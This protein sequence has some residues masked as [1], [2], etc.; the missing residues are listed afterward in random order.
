MQRTLLAIFLS[1]VLGFC[2]SATCIAAQSNIT[3]QLAIASI[4]NSDNLA[5]LITNNNN[6]IAIGTLPSFAVDGWFEVSLANKCFIDYLQINGLTGRFGN[7]SVYYSDANSVWQPFFGYRNIGFAAG[8]FDLSYGN[9]FTGNLRFV[10][11][12]S[13]LNTAGST[14]GG[15]KIY[16]HEAEGPMLLKGTISVPNEALS[17]PKSFL[18]DGNTNTTWRANNVGNA[19]ISYSLFDFSATVSSIK[20]YTQGGSG[21]ATFEAW[22]DNVNRWISLRS[23]VDLGSVADGWHLFET[24]DIST[25][26]IRISISTGSGYSYVGGIAEMQVWG[27]STGEYGQSILLGEKFTGKV[28]FGAR[29]TDISEWDKAEIVATVPAT[30]SS[31]NF[32]LSVNGY[33]ITAV[34]TGSLLNSYR[35]V[36]IPVPIAKLQSNNN[37]VTLDFG[38][39]QVFD[40]SLML[41][42]TAGKIEP[43]YAGIGVNQP[44]LFDRNRFLSAVTGTSSS[45]LAV[46]WEDPVSLD[47]IRLYGSNE[48]GSMTIQSLAYWQNGSW[49]QVPAAD[50]VIDGMNISITG[51]L[52]ATTKIQIHLTA[53]TLNEIELYGSCVS[54]KGAPV[55]TLLTPHSNA[56]YT[57]GETIQVTGYVD[58]P[59]TTVLVNGLAAQLSGYYFSCSLTASTTGSGYHTITVSATDRQGQST[60]KSVI[61]ITG[62]LPSLTCDLASPHYTADA[63]V[64]VTGTS[65]GA[66]RVTINAQAVEVNAGRYSGQVTLTDGE[67]IVAI[68]AINASNLIKRLEQRIILDTKAP[69]LNVNIAKSAEDQNQVEVFGTVN[70]LSP[71]TVTINGKTVNA[72]NGYIDARVT[73]TQRS[74]TVVA[75]DV[76]G[77]RTIV[78]L[79]L[80]NNSEFSSMSIGP[81]GTVTDYNSPGWTNIGDFGAAAGP[82]NGLFSSTREAVSQG[83][84]SI[85]S[86]D[87]TLPGR[88][89]LNLTLKRFYNSGAAFSDSLANQE[90]VFPL[91]PFFG[92]QGWSL[93][94]PCIG[95]KSED[96]DLTTT[97]SDYN[98]YSYGTEYQRKFYLRLPEGQVVE[99]KD[100]FVHIY[101]YD[102]SPTPLY[103]QDGTYKYNKGTHFKAVRVNEAITVTSN[104]GTRFYFD[105]EGMLTRQVDPSGKSE[106]V[107][108]YNGENQ[109]SQIKDSVGRV[110]IFN[111]HPVTKFL[112]SISCNNQP[113]ASYAYDGTTKDLIAVT[114]RKGRKTQYAYEVHSFKS[115][116]NN[117][118]TCNLRLL[119]Q[120]TYPTGGISSYE[121]IGYDQWTKFRA[122]RANWKYYGFKYL[123]QNHRIDGNIIETY[124]YLLNIDKDKTNHE[125]C[126]PRNWMVLASEV[127]TTVAHGRGRIHEEYALISNNAIINPPS[128]TWFVTYSNVIL[129]RMGDYQGTLLYSHTSYIAV[130]ENPNRVYENIV[131]TYDNVTQNMLSEW[132]TSGNNTYSIEYAYDDWGNLTYT[133]DGRTGIAKTVTYKA[134]EAQDTYEVPNR[135]ETIIEKETATGKVL[136]KT[137]YTYKDHNLPNKPDTVTVESDGQTNASCFEY[138]TV[139][140]LTK[141]SVPITGGK[142]LI[143][144]YSYKDTYEN[145]TYIASQTTETTRV[146]DARGNVGNIVTAF[147]Y[148]YFG[149]KDWEMDPLGY[150]T[151]YRYD[152]LQRPTITILPDDNTQPSLNTLPGYLNPAVDLSTLQHPIRMMSYDD[153]NNTTTMLNENGQ[154][155][156]TQYTKFGKPANVKK[157]N[158]GKVVEETSIQYDSQWR[159]T[160]VTDRK[161]TTGYEYDGLDRIVKVIYPATATDGSRAFVTIVYDDDHHTK[162]FTNEN[163]QVIAIETYNLAGQLLGAV[164]RA[165]YGGKDEEYKW[166]YTYD[167]L[168]NKLTVTKPALKNQDNDSLLP[169]AVTT[170][171]YQPLVNKPIA[172]EL[173]NVLGIVAN[174]DN[175]NKNAFLAPA[176]TATIKVSTV[177]DKMG[178]PLQT[179][180]ANGNVTNYVYDELTRLLKTTQSFKQYDY[181]VKTTE[182]SYTYDAAGRKTTVRISDPNAT[183]LD[184]IW[185]YDYSARGQLLK[186]TDPAGNVTQYRYDPAGNKIAVIDPRN[187]SDSANS[188]YQFSGTGVNR[189]VTIRDPRSNKTFTTW[190]LY[191]DLNRPVRTVMPGLA[192]DLDPFGEPTY[193]NPHTDVSYGWNDTHTTT[194]ETDAN[195]V[196]ITSWYNSRNWLT[197]IY[198]NGL[199]KQYFVY[200]NAGN[201]TAEYNIVKGTTTYIHTQYAYDS[202]GRVRKVVAPNGTDVQLFEYDAFGNRIKVSVGSTAT[203]QYK[204]TMYQYNQ[205]GKVV[206]I[207]DPLGNKTESRYDPNGNP[208]AVINAKRDVTIAR[209]DG[210]NRVIKAIDANDDALNPQH[211]VNYRYDSYGNKAGV[212]DRRGTVWVY[213]Y[214]QNNQIRQI[215]LYT[216]SQV[217]YQISYDYDPAGNLITVADNPGDGNGPISAIRYNTD[218]SG[219]YRAD[220]LNR[221]NAVERKFDG[222]TYRT[223]YQYNQGGQ[224]TGLAYPK[225]AGTVNY[226]YDN[227]NQLS[228][229]VGF[230]KS[231]GVSYDP[232]GLLNRLTYQNG[233]TTNFNYDANRRLADLTTSYSGKAIINSHYTYD[234]AS[235][236]TKIHDGIINQDYEYTFDANDQL[237]SALNPQLVSAQTPSNGKNGMAVFDFKGSSA[238]DFSGSD[239]ALIKLD[240]SSNSIGVDLGSAKTILK[241]ELA[242][243][244]T[245]HRLR[246]G[247]LDLYASNDNSLYTLIPTDRWIYSRDANGIVTMKLKQSYRSRYFKIHVKYDDRLA[248]FMFNENKATFLNELAKILRVYEGI[249]QKEVFTYDAAGNRKTVTDSLLNT[250]YSYLY[251]PNTD[252]VMTDGKFAYV[253]DVVGNLI[254]KGNSYT[255]ANNQVTFTATSG[256]SVEYWEYDYDLLNRM[257]AVRK[258]TAETA[259]YGYDSTGIRVVK[260]AHNTKIHYVYEGNEPIY[261]KRFSDQSIHCYV[262][263]FGQYLA[264][265]DGPIDNPS[266]KV[267]YYHNDHLGSIKAVTNASGK[268]VYTADYRAFGKRIQAEGSDGFDEWHGFTGK[269]FDPDANLYYYNARWYDPDL[270]RFISE[271]PSA[272][273]N[274]PNL[275]SYCGNN[276]LTRTDP[277]GRFWWLLFTTLFAGWNSYIHGGSFGDVLTAM[278]SSFITGEFTEG[279]A[280][281]ITFITNS[282][283]RYAV[284]GGI[285]NGVWEGATGGDFGA[286][287]RSGFLTS[288][289]GKQWGVTDLKNPYRFV[290]AGFNGGINSSCHGGSFKNG[291]ATAFGMSFVGDIVDGAEKTYVKTVTEVDPSTAEVMR[292]GN[293]LYSSLFSE[294]NGAGNNYSFDFDI[295][296][297]SD[298]IYYNQ[299]DPRW[300]NIPYTVLKDAN[301]TISSSGCGPT[302]AA[303]V[304]SNLNDTYYTPD[305]A[306]QYAI[307]EKFRTRL[308]CENNLGT[309]WGFFKSIG[310]ANGLMVYQTDDLGIVEMYLNKGAMA[311]ASMGKGHFTRNGHFIVLAESKTTHGLF[312]TNGNGIF[313]L[314]PNSRG[315]TMAWDRTIIQNEAKQYWIF[316]KPF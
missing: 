124:T 25:N 286:G 104:D 254:K 112:S 299:Q 302:S 257:V 224:L 294:G 34:A 214:Y 181:I 159:I 220:P 282:A 102:N 109:L 103:Y 11:Q 219:T 160:A 178:N 287:A 1:V 195:G 133:K 28:S 238:V 193:S 248:D 40:C 142:N 307:K 19:T 134:K 65:S 33:P 64:L 185:H 229:V 53:A 44:N 192:S 285:V 63:T 246:D 180:D 6:A 271:D 4:R 130:E 247:A 47:L 163:Q 217:K 239:T 154:K 105:K 68:E 59:D 200:D 168:G 189:T 240:Y 202:L 99:L 194:S 52:P 136:S 289:F 54:A 17:Y 31:Y 69:V 5:G 232:D 221:I 315:N 23:A 38:T 295:E 39:V 49:V 8:R 101:S 184:R 70:D 50:I 122:P 171:R 179:T 66:N 213:D 198:Q 95:M 276:P 312:N 150:V 235:N 89:G 250:S 243:K 237:L 253:Y 79:S 113:I 80:E 26:Q 77:H 272:D 35:L 314:D 36:R 169:A 176:G 256:S 290:V 126:L 261:E 186:E 275:Y 106:I 27:I 277:T 265:V 9:V 152:E 263:G 14:I 205:V 43:T 45:T 161:G 209:Y 85:S 29:I 108:T 309:N 173:P 164:Q 234:S 303:M 196:S 41:M 146:T 116:A 223:E 140:N 274:N 267:F 162:T 260:W 177:L 93:N 151:A 278:V 117:N 7:V 236:I 83:N 244:A 182:T 118:N 311:I 218:S 107:Y 288:F 222:E 204:T 245:G 216:G 211:P 32:S 251:Y 97:D 197:D 165:T 46:N 304:I 127:T 231:N 58:N 92:G 268:V 132:H 266:S 230:T 183:A 84:L 297:S 175:L 61:Y 119:N 206:W 210:M 212:V 281:Q 42:N 115:S 76:T 191:D 203:N 48:T 131:Y 137:A 258:N 111:Y 22:D 167:A 310:K 18:C 199:R 301:Q 90:V 128:A 284:A 225:A 296:P 264:R 135:A 121:Y 201:K 56:Q 208:V 298:F 30:V 2:V 300:G 283:L 143:A 37:I 55:I 110:V 291:F 233:V 87:L 149:Q 166:S 24:A 72:S 306:A 51:G 262:F 172:Q 20:L 60:Q 94:I 188:W 71:V 190:Y 259:R 156:V 141:K 155:T 148:N 147:H 13:G 139:G 16:G 78:S 316:V 129:P 252:R 226:R 62:T 207:K 15:I 215:N 81:T 157:Y 88:N 10:I 100:L 21:I 273:P 241:F 144:T 269:E 138:D 280:T 67:N 73:L 170:Y 270:G 313:V 86:V 57:A 158:Q 308:E 98:S 292:Y 249:Y 305:L 187:P 125:N 228:E 255:I 114:D 153:A 293:Q 96:S 242:P 12:A 91:K 75:T 82:F 145:S 174:P 123:V 120:I 227:L 3:N 279:L 74:I